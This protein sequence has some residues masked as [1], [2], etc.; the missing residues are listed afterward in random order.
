MNPLL[1]EQIVN[2]KKNGSS[3]EAIGKKYGVTLKHIEKAITKHYG[4]NISNPL[5][6]KKKIV[7][8]EPKSFEPETTTVWS[9]KSRGNWATH[10]GNYRGNWSPYIPRN[11]IMKYSKEG[12]L[13]LDYFCGG[14][15]TAVE[16][17]LLNR[18]FIGIDINPNAIK[19]ATE[20]LN[21]NGRLFAS[22]I[23]LRIGDARSLST[24]LN[25]SID[26]ICAHPP[27]AD[28]VN[29]THNNPSDLSSKGV[30]DFLKEMEKVASES[31][32]VLK[33]NSYCAIL[34]GDMRKNKN[35]IPLGFWTIE[36]YLAAG[37]SIKELIIKRQH[38]CKT[39]GFWYSNSVKYNFLLLAHEYLVVF[40]KIS[41][42]A[43][44]IPEDDTRITA[45]SFKVDKKIY[46]ESTTVWIFSKNEWLG[47][48]IS[49]LFKRYSA[50]KPIFFTKGHKAG[51]CDLII[52]TR[53]DD[54]DASIKYA[55]INL[56]NEGIF[57]VICQDKRCKNGLVKSSVMDIEKKMRNNGVLKQKELVVVSIESENPEKGRD[58]EIAHKYIIIYKK[59][60][61]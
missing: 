8:I 42:K 40:Q 61:S 21:F 51:P 49:N 29:Y 28:I 56:E 53:A 55:E 17:R 19:L 12:D 58:L 57:A 50:K 5:N 33:P 27:Y 46:L 39:T 7:N 54:I 10:N 59:V 30:N 44:Q 6:A 34:I 60:V 32:R 18:D 15:T 48:T 13:V 24:I 26:L 52:S 22:K 25:N 16:S 37:F 2:E 14:G 20:N 38:N 4:I 23:S 31:Y 3:D 43:N 9:F 1:L 35:V 41:N 11:V 47:K 45:K 36:K